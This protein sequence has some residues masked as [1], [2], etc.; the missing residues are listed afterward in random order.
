MALPDPDDGIRSAQQPAVGGQ[1]KS[2]DSPAV[3]HPRPKDL[4]W[5][6]TVR[7]REAAVREEAVTPALPATRPLALLVPVPVPATP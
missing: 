7:A 3:S 4:S 2:S 1:A 6:R 5:T